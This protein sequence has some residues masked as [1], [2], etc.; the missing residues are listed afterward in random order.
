MAPACWDNNESLLRFI[1]TVLPRPTY[2]LTHPFLS[3]QLN[4]HYHMYPS[5]LR[6]EMDF[7]GACAAFDSS[8]N[9]D[10]HVAFMAPAQYGRSTDSPPAATDTTTDEDMMK[11]DEDDDEYRYA[12]GDAERVTRTFASP[13]AA[14]MREKN[15][16]S[17]FRSP[18]QSARDLLSAESLD[19]DGSLPLDGS[20]L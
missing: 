13:S 10:Q 2:D 7:K 4:P 15:P 18:L 17:P 14:A 9:I 8:A 3:N 6:T 12:N 1:V 5:S 11:T 16:L 19:D 20:M